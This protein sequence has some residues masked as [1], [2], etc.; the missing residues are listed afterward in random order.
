MKIFLLNIAA[1]VFLALGLGR[2]SGFK[3][4]DSRSPM[5]VFG[6]V[7]EMNGAVGVL[8]LALAPVCWYL[9]HRE[10]SK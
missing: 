5:E 8:C 6:F 1:L 2:L 9:A 3:F 4:S 10:A 7:D